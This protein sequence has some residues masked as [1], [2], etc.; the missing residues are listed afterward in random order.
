MTRRSGVQRC[1]TVQPNSLSDV[2]SAWYGFLHR[3]YPTHFSREWVGFDSRLLRSRL[4]S[5]LQNGI[6]A[7]GQKAQ[8]FLKR[9][10]RERSKS[11]DDCAW[12]ERREESKQIVSTMCATAQIAAH[13]MI[14]ELPQA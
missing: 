9:A 4:K 2:K 6:L 3:K 5:V 1:S 14:I 11:I 7:L 8:N 13:S 10:A 12:N